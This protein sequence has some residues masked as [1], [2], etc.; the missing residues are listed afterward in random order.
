MKRV[1]SYILFLGLA[2]IL[3]YFSFREVKW[4]DF[5]EGFRTADYS[6]ILLSMLFGA[7]TFWIRGI[8]WRLLIRGAGYQ[9]SKMSAFDAVNI[10]YIT[11]F[12]FPRAGEVARCGVL[13]KTAGA[14]FDTLLG[15]VV[16]ERTFDALCLIVITALVIVLQWNVFGVFMGQQL[17]NPF[18]DMLLGKT[19]YIIVILLTLTVLFFLIIAYRKRLQKLFVFK[20]MYELAIGIYRGLKS[21]FSLRQRAPFL[22]YTFVLWLLY[23]AT[24]RCTILAFS[25]V[26]HL[27]SLDTLFLMVVGSLGWVVPVQGGVGAYHFIVSLALA[28]VYGVDQTQSLVFATIS[29]EAQAVTMILFGLFSLIRVGLAKKPENTPV[30]DIQNS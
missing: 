24:C 21:G 1:I 18:I 19:I 2:V 10:A 8:R 14:P 28:S 16:L 26:T 30:L 12:A 7:F 9:V 6:W 27:D 17:W 11:N 29:H 23:W 3:L 4:S 13:V 25:N 5:M 20:K 22:C 15:T